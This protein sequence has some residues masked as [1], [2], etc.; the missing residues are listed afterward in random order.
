MAQPADLPGVPAGPAHPSQAAEE[1]AVEGRHVFVGDGAVYTV[2]LYRLAG[3][4][5]PANSEFNTQPFAYPA[6]TGGLWVNADVS[7]QRSM[8]TG[9]CDEGCAA[10]LY[11]ELLYATGDQ[12]VVPGHD[13]AS[14]STIINATGSQLP[15]VWDAAAAPPGGTLVKVRFYFRDAVVYAL[16]HS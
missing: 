9:G 1:G 3:L 11:C 16:G 8:Q 12:S 10:Y 4:Y 13:A 2:P 6:A 5:S 7:W 14:F 15:L